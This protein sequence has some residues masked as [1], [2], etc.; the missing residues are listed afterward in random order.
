MQSFRG[1]IS[2]QPRLERSGFTL[3]ELLVVISIIATLMSLLLPAMQNAR[4][5]ARR[6]QCLN[7]MRQVGLAL[8][9]F[10]AKDTGQQFP[11]YGTWGDGENVSGRWW[12]GGKNGFPKRNWVVE[13]LSELDRQDIYDRW[14]FNR[15]PTSTLIRANG[16]SNVK[17]AAEY[18]L[19]VLVCPEDD[20]AQ[21][22]AHSLSYVVNAG[23]AAI[24]GR[25]LTPKNGAWGNRFNAHGLSDPDMDL[26]AN[27]KKNEPKD[28]ELMRRSGVMWRAVID[29]DRKTRFPVVVP[30]RS[31]G[32]GNIYDGA[33]NTILLTENLNAG[34]VEYWTHPDPRNCAFVFPIN[35]RRAGYD[36]SNYFATVPLD[37]RFPF[38]R[39]N[40]AKYGPDGQRPFPNSNHIDSVNM[41][42]CDGSTR[43]FSEH[44]DLSVYVRLMSPAGDMP[45]ATIT[46]QNPIDALNL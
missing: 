32:P 22:A 34:G 9:A 24:D 29:R 30:N 31:F 8:H 44:I 25:E 17:L 21:E 16:W 27:G 5:A 10:A 36:A 18:S 45:D 28:S 37:P 23:Y 20:T 3:I 39:I 26:D 46:P 14:D 4:R 33:S 12:T 13:I 1:H 35:F 41:V 19:P 11:P 7:N 15:G 38:G 2:Q 40:G 42:L 6:T 43:S